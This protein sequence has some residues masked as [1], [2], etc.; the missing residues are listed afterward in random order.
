MAKIQAKAPAY[1][2]KREAEPEDRSMPVDAQE[3]IPTEPSQA[4]QILAALNALSQKM[5]NLETKT[6]ANSQRIAAMTA[7]EAWDEHLEDTNFH[8]GSETRDHFRSN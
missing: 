2:V 4:A 3:R 1:R 7:T 5:T 8:T 6:D